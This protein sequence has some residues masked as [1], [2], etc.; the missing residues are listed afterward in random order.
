M[1]F[2]VILLNIILSNIVHSYQ[3]CF[4]KCHKEQSSVR[5]D[6]RLIRDILPN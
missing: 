6:T 3:K 2:N 1:F 5:N 4:I